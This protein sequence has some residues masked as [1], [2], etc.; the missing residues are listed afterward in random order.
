VTRASAPPSRIVIDE[1]TPLVDGGRHPVKRVVGEPVTVGARVF[2]DGHD[3]LRVVVSH[4]PP[5][6]SRWT[7]VEMTSVNPGLDRWEAT[8]V[9]EL[10][11]DH[12][13]RVRA[14]IDARATWRDALARKVEAGADEPIDHEGEPPARFVAA[15][16]ETSATVAVRVE[17]VRAL[18]STWYE[19]FPRSA[20]C[21]GEH[22]TLA[23]VTA[24]LDDIADHGFDVVYLPPI[25]PIGTSFR[26]GP[27]NVEGA[28][29]GDPGS[30]WAI[31][32][33]EGGH[34]AVHPE[35]GTLADFD[36]LV[37]AA[38]EREMDIALDLAFQCSPDHPWVTEHP[39]WFRHRPDGTIQYAENPPKRYQDIYPLDFASADWRGL[40]DALLEVTLF[41]SEHGV[42]TFRV[43][44]PHTKPYA[45][46]EW[47]LAEVTVRH[48]G[49]IFLS[50][51]FTRPAP[52]HRLAQLGFT[53]SYTYFPWRTGRDELVDYFT[54]L[55]TPPS[56]DE[57]RPSV[58]P[59]TPDILPWHL[60]HAPI[61]TFALRLVLAATLSPSYG[62]YGPAFELGDNQPAG[63]GKEEYLDSEKYQLRQW[64]L[65]QPLNLRP[66]VAEI[67][68]IRR[69]HLAFHTL[70]TLHFHGCDNGAL[71]CFSKT[72]HEGPSVDPE[73]PS[74]ATMLVVVNL[75]PY[76]SESGTLELDLGALGVDPGRPYEVD[77]L[78]GGCR[79]TWEGDRPWVELDP[80]RQPAHVLRLSQAPADE[81]PPAPRPS[82][83]SPAGRGG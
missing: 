56:V 8:F 10:V 2:A 27:N 64:D 31:G 54:E 40:W 78:L 26:K 30:P 7:E 19:L 43:D 72:P 29:P 75:D 42:R 77:D 69:D 74:A 81:W 22:G 16:A 63:N 36:A 61:A 46:W 21:P 1:I 48:P 76:L 47:L 38:R 39:T 34:T 4:R 28:G 50:E 65:E 45:F 82:R 52:M 3:R 15:D 35:L 11:G 57:L 44:N 32:A 80:G 71:I 49:T 62:I 59:N 51:A 83:T 66:L 12:D 13:V 79:Y 14:W 68:A 41:W 37:A 70:R 23:D 58:W 33:P 60:Q 24:R 55:S 73:R 6:A 20:G 9:P 53:Q 5:G 67:N 25:H 17:P 18:F